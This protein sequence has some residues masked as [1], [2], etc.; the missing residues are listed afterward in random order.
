VVIEAWLSLPLAPP[1]EHVL[2][3]RAL[4]PAGKTSLLIP[5]LGDAF[6]APANSSIDEAPA[7]L[8]NEAMVAG[9]QPALN[10]TRCVSTE[11]WVASAAAAAALSLR[12]VRPPAFAT[13]W[14]AKVVE[15]SGIASVD[16]ALSQ[17]VLNGNRRVLEFAS[18]PLVCDAS[19]P[20]A[21]ELG[22]PPSCAAPLVIMTGANARPK[23]GAHAVAR[24]VTTLATLLFSAFLDPPALP[25]AILPAFFFEP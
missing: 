20:L 5:Q 3:K 25:F 17:L 21:E 7:V 22:D 11:R 14:L 24:A 8:R 6:R 16:N 13:P 19:K 1:I 4:S 12:V 10:A 18:W 15:A 9:P 23:A 2:A